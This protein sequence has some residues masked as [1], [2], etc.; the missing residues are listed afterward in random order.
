MEAEI[1][2]LA[3]PPGGCAP[4]ATDTATSSATSI[5]RADQRRQRIADRLPH[6]ELY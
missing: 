3:K 1:K 6:V 4:H 2:Q 5:D